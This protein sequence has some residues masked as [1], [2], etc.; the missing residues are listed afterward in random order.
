MSRISSRMDDKLHDTS[1]IEQVSL[2]QIT[3]TLTDTITSALNKGKH[4]K[5]TP[6]DG[7][8]SYRADEFIKDYE[9]RSKAKNW[10]E[11]NKFDK[12]GLYLE[13]VAKDWY[14]LVTT[15]IDDPPCDWEELKS[16]F[17][18]EFLP[19]NCKRY[20]REHALRR[21]QG[22]RE[23]VSKYTIQKRMLCYQMNSDLEENE[24]IDLIFEGFLPEIKKDLEVHDIRSIDSLI[25]KA[26]KIEK[27]LTYL[28]QASS[29]NSVSQSSDVQEKLIIDYLKEFGEKMENSLQNLSTEISEI[30]KISD[31][32][33]QMNPHFDPVYVQNVKQHQ[34]ETRDISQ[35]KYYNHFQQGNQNKFNNNP[36]I[37]NDINYRYNN[38][39]A[40][41]RMWGYTPFEEP[42][43]S[44]LN[45]GYQQKAY[46]QM[47]VPFQMWSNYNNQEM[48][49]NPNETFPQ[50]FARMQPK[51][52]PTETSET[53]D[54]DRAHLVPFNPA[55]TLP[56][57]VNL[58]NESGVNINPH[59]RV[60]RK[61][62]MCRLSGHEIKSCPMNT[63]L[64]LN[65]NS[66]LVENM[67]E[68]PS[69]D[70]N[71]S[72]PSIGDN[73]I[74]SLNDYDSE[75]SSNDE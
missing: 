8:I 55:P 44:P 11:Q 10:S 33:E 20:Y 53:D 3:K 45:A 35:P 26:R 51:F 23:P 61:C 31:E 21:K 17:L 66:C 72:E 49:F 67:S 54:Q 7:E 63:G 57:E 28:P 59:P 30:K 25:T 48:P 65:T 34:D 19:I 24:L 37:S 38:Y 29:D 74:M 2:K 58:E 36:F 52:L 18:K 27:G 16:S 40:Q 69:E 15:A 32:K 14:R 73:E 42:Q 6:Y 64:N 62:Y 75:D 43:Y 9:D 12:F 4:I 56:K 41:P 68:T 5:L 60:R 50:T 39:R 47:F 71:Y 22:S 70:L 13:G 46:N 1:E